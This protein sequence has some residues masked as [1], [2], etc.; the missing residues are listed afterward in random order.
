MVIMLLLK[1]SGRRE[2]G[3]CSIARR[4]VQ[5]W[6][7]ERGALADGDEGAVMLADAVV[8]AQVQV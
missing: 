5:L 2:R 6:N 3:V 8:R 4:M 1:L 7:G